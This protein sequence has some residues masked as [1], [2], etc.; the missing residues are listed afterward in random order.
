MRIVTADYSQIELRVLAHLSK[1]PVLVD[2]F[3]TGQDVHA[4]TA[5]EVFSVASSG[6]TDE[7]RRMAKTIN[8]GVIYGM[9]EVALA[10]RLDIPRSEAAAFIEAYFKRYD[11]VRSFMDET[12]ET[13]RRGEAVRTL[14]G[15]QRLLPNIRSSN[16]ILR[17]AA[18]R[19]QAN[20]LTSGDGRRSASSR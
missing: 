14:F 10:K 7:M 6:V 17:A 12:L 5:M 13:A 16:G 4:R 3:R 20:A 19:S 18:E 9:G 2:A 11:R 8:F 1:D 15:R